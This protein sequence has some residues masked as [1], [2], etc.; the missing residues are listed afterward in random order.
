MPIKK[1][2]RVRRRYPRALAAEPLEPR[3]LLTL[4]TVTSTADEGPGTFRQ[5]LYD[6][7]GSSGAHAIH[8]NI[9]PGGRQRITIKWD[10]PKISKSLTIDGTTQPGY[11]G[12]PLIEVIALQL[13]DPDD[14]VR[15][16]ELAGDDGAVRG[17]AIEGFAT[18]LRVSGQNN[19]IRGNYFGLNASGNSRYLSWGGLGIDDFVD[20]TADNNIVGGTD[21]ADRNVISG[22]Q[23]GLYIGGDNTLVQGNYIGTDPTG[24]LPRPNTGRAIDLRSDNNTIGGTVAAARNV[25]AG[26][27]SGVNI[28]QT[29][30][31]VPTGNRVLGNYI[32]VAADGQTPLGN[33]G[34]GV[35][36]E[37]DGPNVI[38]GREPGAANVI[39]HNG[40]AGVVLQSPE[41]A[42]G[43]GPV[44][45]AGNSFHSN[46]GLAIDLGA[47]GVSPNDPLDADEGHN[48]L[49][50]F[51]V[52]LAVYP[53]PDSTVIDVSLHSKALT[54]YI[55]DFYANPRSDPSTHGEAATHLGS[56]TVTS[57]A[58][59]DLRIRA[60][61][62]VSVSA[63]HVISATAT[64]PTGS[65]SE[66]SENV[67]VPLPG[68]ANS[69]ENVDFND[70]A[71]LAQNYNH[72]NTTWPQGDFSGDGK[73]DF[74]D[75]A[76]LAQNYNTSA[77]G[78]ASLVP[79]VGGQCST[80]PIRP[81]A[82]ARLMAVSKRRPAAVFG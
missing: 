41:R 66:L 31:A 78:A 8:F 63:G 19:V 52:L 80:T 2:R 9:A 33:T 28:I 51:P 34:H 46:T 14:R 72:I 3:T 49:Q 22:N 38:G 59:G 4:F 67:K 60:K 18:N 53:R 7:A 44:S 71:A 55:L 30:S 45:I 48:G 42:V 35:L 16:L 6:A 69:D 76:L 23:G 68:D 5:A 75:L 47:R 39:A 15:G 43:K 1:R 40:G 26:N 24:M 29:G 77:D 20:G 54:S 25:I 13:A 70:L 61:V 32:G 62:P 56:I 37:T 65:T 17:L 57:D 10:L 50:N 58:R 82:P 74:E 79:M 64:D 27:G 36:A 12:S 11:A 81:A 21:P 73:T